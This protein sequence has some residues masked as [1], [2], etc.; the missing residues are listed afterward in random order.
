MFSECYLFEPPN[1]VRKSYYK[2]DRKFHLDD[3]LDLYVVHDTYAIVLISGKRTDLYIHSKNNTQLI[4]SVK[5]ELPNQ[6]KTGGSSA[7]RF[8][9][10]RDEKIN[11]YVKRISELMTIL[12]TKD[13]LFCH[14][15]LFLAGPSQLKDQLQS[16]PLFVQHFQKYLS[17]TITIPEITDQSVNYVIDSITNTNTD[18][19]LIEKFESMLANPDLIDLFVF[20]TTDVINCYL[21]GTLSE[22]F[23]DVDSIEIIESKSEIKT[24]I[25]LI[26]DKT[27]IKK[28]GIAIGIKYYATDTDV[29]EI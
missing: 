16:T 15:G 2:C 11:L 20:G 22:I 1:P 7:P 24:I 14:L 29:I 9:R 19:K 17:K 27:F 23:I 18:T 26:Y 10:I 21:E 13:N 4:K 28:Y 3:L 6:H 5:T 8:G 25:N 12:F